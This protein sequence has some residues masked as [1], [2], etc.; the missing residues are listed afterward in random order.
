MPVPLGGLAPE[1]SHALRLA[2]K[3]EAVTIYSGTYYSGTVR[4][5]EPDE[6]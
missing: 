4:A 5:M 2:E 1:W 3:G 6:S